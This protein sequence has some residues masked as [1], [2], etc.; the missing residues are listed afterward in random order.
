MPGR[1]SARVWPRASVCGTPKAW[2]SGVASAHEGQWRKA[3]VRVDVDMDS[4]CRAPRFLGGVA[5]PACF[6]TRPDSVRL[7]SNDQLIH[8]MEIFQTARGLSED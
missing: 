2:T 5:A 8:Q 1:R 6:R 4:T 3:V 7:S